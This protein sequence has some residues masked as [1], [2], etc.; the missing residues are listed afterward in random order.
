M[1][2]SSPTAPGQPLFR[3]TLLCLGGLTLLNLLFSGSVV[4]FIGALVILIMVWG[5]HRGD[6]P[7]TRALGIL[8]YVYAVVNLAVM[9]LVLGSGASARISS[10]IWL[11]L[12]SLSL[13]AMGTIL[14]SSAVQGFLQNATPPEKK[15]RKIHFFHGGWRDL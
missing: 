15:K 4:S 6:Y 5:I 3:F 10:L 7:L 2:K 11:G 12:Y 13:I 9:A 14:R 1:K 8:L